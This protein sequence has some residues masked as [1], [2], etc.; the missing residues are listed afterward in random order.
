[1][2]S[3]SPGRWCCSTAT[4]ATALQVLDARTGATAIVSQL[5]SG[6]QPY[7]LVRGGV[8]AGYTFSGSFKTSPTE[9]VR[10]D[11]TKLPELHC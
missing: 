10:I 1:M 8:F 9:V 3:R 6:L 11:V 7:G 5:G 4:P 2:S